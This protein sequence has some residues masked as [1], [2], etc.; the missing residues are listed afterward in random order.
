MEGNQAAAVG[1]ES[2]QYQASN[3]GSFGATH[4]SAFCTFAVDLAAFLSEFGG[5]QLLPAG[6]TCKTGQVV[7]LPGKAKQP[8]SVKSN[9]RLSFFSVQ[10]Y[11]MQ[12]KAT[13]FLLKWKL[14]M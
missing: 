13:G 14:L 6:R 7:D 8:C 12:L 4:C 3:A 1:T 11:N 10:Q 9:S 5:V 2:K